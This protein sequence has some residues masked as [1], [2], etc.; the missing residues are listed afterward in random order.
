MYLL[1]FLVSCH[2]IE[3]IEPPSSQP[4]MYEGFELQK[5]KLKFNGIDMPTDV[6]LE[7]TGEI[8]KK[9]EASTF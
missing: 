8:P 2:S 1:L 3:S 9:N 5:G 6:R 7:F 4:T